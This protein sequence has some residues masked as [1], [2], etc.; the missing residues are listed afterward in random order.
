MKIKNIECDL[1]LT[2]YSLF[3]NT[4]KEENKGTNI[5]RKKNNEA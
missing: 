5:S 3:K 2:F 1:N 4:T